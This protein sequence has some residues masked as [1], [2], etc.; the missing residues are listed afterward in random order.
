LDQ[1]VDS[2]SLMVGHLLEDM[3]D[4]ANRIATTLHDC[5]LEATDYHQAWADM[6]EV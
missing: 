3:E 6:R 2:I 1:Y 4:Q 5:G